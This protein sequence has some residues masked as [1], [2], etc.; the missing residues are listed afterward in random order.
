MLFTSAMIYSMN[1]N[2]QDPEETCGTEILHEKLM[3]T[4]AQYR[5]DFVQMEARLAEKV[6]ELPAS[7]TESAYT[8]PAV[9]HV[10]HLGEKEGT[11]SNISTYKFIGHYKA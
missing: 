5:H 10:I 6:H 7:K 9:V 4:D 8:I 3:Q 1:I 2:A 11:D